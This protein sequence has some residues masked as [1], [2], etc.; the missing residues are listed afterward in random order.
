MSHAHRKQSPGRCDHCGCL[1]V[2]V[3]LRD[4]ESEH[5]SAGQVGWQCLVCN[6]TLDR[7]T[8]AQR[9]ERS[10]VSG[11]GAVRGQKDKVIHA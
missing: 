2:L 4:W 9:Q 11:F 5:L 10:S 1:M 7:E 6:R 3:R 8:M